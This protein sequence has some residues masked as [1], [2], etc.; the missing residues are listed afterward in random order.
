MEVTTIMATTN[1]EQI[2]AWNG[3]SGRAWIDA[4]ATLDGMFHRF[5]EVLASEARGA[6]SR[7]ILDVGCGTGATTL[8]LS[9]AAGPGAHCVGV[10]LSQP[11]IEV[12]RERAARAGSRAQFMA[13]DAGSLDFGTA[14]FD[15]FVSRFGVMF[16]AEPV[17]AFAHLREAAADGALLRCIS[18]RSPAEN[19]FMTAAERAAAP[20]LPDLPPRDPQA[21]GQFA[22]ADPARVHDILSAAGWS[23]VELRP[24]DV[25]CSLSASELDD[26]MTRLGP[27]A[28]L[29][30]DL[31]DSVR[32][33]VLAAMRTG[34]APYMHANEARYTAA[35]WMI[36][37]HA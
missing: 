9:E 24:L 33:R 12:A 25:E 3:P 30:P 21:P 16:F 18:W 32:S 1:D 35:C 37:A 26:Y 17:L 31:D 29:L 34:F 27:I 13:G 4:Q 15:L 2:Q 10:D 7:A 20:W 28:R 6:Q 8:A 22:F 11:M 36:A 19:P 23:A 5:A 14:R